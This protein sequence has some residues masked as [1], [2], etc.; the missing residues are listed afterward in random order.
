[1]REKAHSSI[2]D[3]VNAAFATNGGHEPANHGEFSTARYAFLFKPGSY[4][5]DVPVGFYTQVLGLGASPD[6]VTFTGAKGV[7]CEEGSYDFTIGALDNFWRGAEN[8]RSLATQAWWD[9]AAGINQRCRDR[10]KDRN[11]PDDRFRE[12]VAQRLDGGIRSL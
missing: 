6:D 3:V 7:Y 9:G 12:K 8:F 4:S 10:R 5:V 11:G 1:M 2:A